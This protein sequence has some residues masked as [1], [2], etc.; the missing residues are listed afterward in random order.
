MSALCFMRWRS[1][2][3]AANRFRHHRLLWCIA[4]WHGP[5]FARFD[6]PSLLPSPT[7][8]C[9]AGWETLRRP[10]ACCD[11][12][13]CPDGKLPLRL[14]AWRNEQGESKLFTVGIS[15]IFGS[16]FALSA[17]AIGCQFWRTEH[18]RSSAR[19]RRR[20]SSIARKKYPQAADRIGTTGRLRVTE[21]A[22]HIA[23]LRRSAAVVSRRRIGGAGDADWAL[24]SGVPVVTTSGP[25]TDRLLLSQQK[26]CC[27]PTDL[28]SPPRGARTSTGESGDGA[29][30]GI[31]SSAPLPGILSS[32]R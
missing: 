31:S 12:Q 22:K 2:S 25:A 24:A 15:P 20:V 18:R 27:L 6:I 10:S 32:P 4:S 28:R 26:R 19:A 13:Q 9:S 14:L 7:W 16:N 30:I 23:K 17:P 3:A 29:G 21:V 8:P 11:L 5:S 1:L